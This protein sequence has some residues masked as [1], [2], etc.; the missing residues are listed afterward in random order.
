MIFFFEGAFTV[1][2][3]VIAFFFIV[4]FPHVK[5]RRFLTPRDH[6]RQLYRLECDRDDLEHD[7]LTMKKLGLYLTEPLGW[8]YMFVAMCSTVTAYALTFFLPTILFFRLKF[9]LV[10]AQCLASPPFIFAVVVAGIGAYISDRYKI[11]APVIVANAGLTMIGLGLLYAKGLSPAVQYFAVFL[12]AAGSNANIPAVMTYVMNNCH[13]SS[14]RAVRSAQ[15]VGGGALGGIAGSLVFRQVDAPGYGP[16][17]A[18]CLVCNAFIILITG[19]LTV[20]FRSENKKQDEGNIIAGKQGF[21]YA[22]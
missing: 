4:E 20:F 17:L 21:R 19:A 11:R 12:I 18:A 2:I 3:G 22:I 16:G 14:R 1:I 7:P 9:T 8:I 10:K 13:T 6:A 15:F 5:K